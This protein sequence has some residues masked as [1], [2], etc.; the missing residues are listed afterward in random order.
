MAA[1]PIICLERAD[2]AGKTPDDIDEESKRYFVGRGYVRVRLKLEEVEDTVSVRPWYWLDNE[3]WP[4]RHDAAPG[5]G[6]EPVTADGAVLDGKAEGFFV[7]GGLGCWMVLIVEEG[8]V[9]YIQK[10]FL[11]A[12][13]AAGT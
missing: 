4:L 13:D 8:D 5:V 6:T 12:S 11:D 2:L 7:T 1:N 10:A 9:D 3:W